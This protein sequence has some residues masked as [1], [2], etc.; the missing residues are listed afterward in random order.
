MARILVV[1]DD[2]QIRIM[3]EIALSRDSHEVVTAENGAVASMRQSERP[4]DVV[5][6]DIIM[7]E[8]EGFETIIEFRREYPETKIIAISGGGR[9][10]PDHYL[11]L[12][13]TMGADFIFEKPLQ[14]LQLREAIHSLVPA[15]AKE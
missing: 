11:K 9:L 6:M 15:P 10:G 1:D 8:K 7:P 12:A 2:E 3:L 4:A 14:I 13:K 5:I